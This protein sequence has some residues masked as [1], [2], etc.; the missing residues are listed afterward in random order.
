[1]PD[2][3]RLA[4]S[5]DVAVGEESG[6][7]ESSTGALVNYTA[8]AGVSHDFNKDLSA[9]NGGSLSLDG[10][11]FS[12]YGTL[13]QSGIVGTTTFS[14]ATA[15]RLDTVWSYDDETNLRDIRAGDITSGGLVWTRP[16]RLGGGQGQRNFGLNRS[17]V[18]M[19]RPSV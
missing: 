9:I 15:L 13:N 12:R 3:S 4:K 2:S 16:I 14:D 7:A 11:A 18:T 8:Y 19:P 10:R 17:L 5:Y 6:K 1:A